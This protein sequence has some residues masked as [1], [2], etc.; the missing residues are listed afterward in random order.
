MAQLKRSG[1]FVAPGDRLGV[2][3][4][5]TPGRGTYVN[6]G[7]IYAQT[8]GHA[9]LDRENKK[10]SVFQRTRIPSI[11][12]QG[13]VVIAQV[14]NVQDKLATLKIL[15]NANFK[16][17]FTAILHVSFVSKYFVDSLHEAFRPGDIVLAEVI[18]D[19][20]LPYQ[21]TTARRDLGVL[22]AYCSICGS[23]LVLQRKRLVCEGCGNFERRKTSENYGK[24][25]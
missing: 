4:E 8:T 14:Q 20:N 17:P 3:E 12:R 9:L 19:K 23:V 24:V 15:K 13:H 22:Q 16:K 11:P 7:V 5:F 6:D 21:L 25:N 18:G 1:Q 2:I 10:I